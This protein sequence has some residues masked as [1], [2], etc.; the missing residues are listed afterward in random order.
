LYHSLNC[1]A[2]Q[3]KLADINGTDLEFETFTAPTPDHHLKHFGAFP[4]RLIW[5]SITPLLL[6]IICIGCRE[7]A[8]R[9]NFTAEPVAAGQS[10]LKSESNE[11]QVKQ[12]I[13]RYNELLAEGYRTLNM[14]RLGEVA[15][16]TQAE[17]AYRHM[18]AIGEGTARMLSTL[19]A[20]DF[21]NL[22]DSKVNGYVVTTREVW[23]FSYT[24]IKTGAVKSSEKDFPYDVTYTLKHDG[25]RWLITDIVASSPRDSVQKAAPSADQSVTAP[26]RSPTNLPSE[27]GENAN[28]K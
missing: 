7:K 9:Q 26:S 5:F 6:C 18:A 13:R 25:Q 3:R 16:S 19:K 4:M 21:T 12:V 15:T 20:I 8:Q 11:D 10:P 24:D 1:G 14:N 28:S 2:G 27:Q 17:K 22:Q 23:D